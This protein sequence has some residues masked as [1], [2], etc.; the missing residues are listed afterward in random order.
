MTTS[1]RRGFLRHLAG[2]LARG[3]REV[4]PVLSPVPL[5]V[6]DPTPRTPEPSPEPAERRPPPTVAAGAAV[7]CVSERELLA[8]ADEHGL[9][10]R[11]DAVRTLARR[12]VRIAP[13][14]GG[15][16]RTS[17]LGG[18]PE[19][20]PNVEWPTW[21][22]DPLP[23]VARIDLAAAAAGDDDAQPALPEHGSLLVFYATHGVPS[24]L[25]LAHA[26]AVAVRWSAAAPQAS[27]PSGGTPATLSAERTL[28]RV[29][30]APV[31]T[32]G[33]DPD[34]QQ[35]W[36][37]LR[38]RLAELQGAELA[39]EA[40]T[41]GA[42][43]ALHRLLGYP[44]ERR[45]TMPAICEAAARG[46]DLAE[47][48]P[49]GHPAVGELEAAAGRWRLLLQLSADD[50]VGLSWRERRERLYLWIPADDLRARDFSRVWAIP[51]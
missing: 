17:Q 19:L 39:D 10:R 20:P 12:S 48:P 14:P 50:A 46:I 15:D 29:W 8:L 22:G 2:E 5:D 51:Q 24:G 43:L 3:A 36:Q 9:G 26:G 21:N 13:A 4:A 47:Q 31:Q 35:G 34:E 40:D 32:L 1:N 11:L 27:D 30:S 42:T 33:L 28:P 45:G 44:D 16:A 18:V 41:D 38:R 25:S 23:F 6:L 7:R 37:Q 49:H